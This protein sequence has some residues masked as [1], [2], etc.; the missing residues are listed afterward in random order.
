MTDIQEKISEKN[1]RNV[2]ARVFYAR[3]D[4]DAIAAWKEELSKILQIFHVC[5]VYSV[6]H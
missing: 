1:E 5:S 2:F 4:K 6:R 3:S